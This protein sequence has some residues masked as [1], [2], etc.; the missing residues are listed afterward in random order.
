MRTSMVYHLLKVKKGSRFS[1]AA[2]KLKLLFDEF[3]VRGWNA[4]II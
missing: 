1:A 2:Q 3:L 4:A